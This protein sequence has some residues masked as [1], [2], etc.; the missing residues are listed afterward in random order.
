MKKNL[1]LEIN[2]Q[3]NC[4]FKLIVFTKAK[5]EMNPFC[6]FIKFYFSK[7]LQFMKMESNKRL[8]LDLD[9]RMHFP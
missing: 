7:G 6:N 5:R 1:L 9:L 2:V 3:K 8:L 4:I